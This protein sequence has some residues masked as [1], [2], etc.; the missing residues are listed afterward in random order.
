M[1]TDTAPLRRLLGNTGIN[2][3]SLGFGCY[4]VIDGN[5]AHEQALRAYLDRGGNLID[6]SANYGD[7]LAETMVEKVLQDYPDHGTILVTKGGYIQGQNMALAMKQ[8][9]PE[10]VE[11][12][13]GIW[14]CI[15]PEFLETQLR[16]SMQRLRRNYLEVYLLHNPEYYLEDQS[17]KGAVDDNHRKEFYRRVR[18]AFAFLESKVAAG[19]LGWYGISSNNFGHPESQ[20]TATSIARCWAAAESVSP[21]HHFRVVQLPLNVF[22]SGGALE[23]NNET[24]TALDYCRER[25]IGVLANRPLNA[26]QRNS[27]VRLADFMRP[28]EAAPAREQIASIVEPVSKMEKELHEQFEVPLFSGLEGGIAEYMSKMLPQIQSP[29]HWEQVYY[30]RLIQPIER[31]AMECQQLYGEHNE[32]KQWWARFVEMIPAVFEEAARYVSKSQQKISDHVRER[33]LQAGYPPSPP[34]DKSTLSQM[35]LNTLLNLDG[36]SC[37][38]VGMRRREYVDDCF[39]A[40]ALPRFDA[41][42]VLGRFALMQ[43]QTQSGTVQ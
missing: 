32:W 16:R 4:R 9:F 36:L 25:G 43:A 6:T 13:E 17:H 41:L 42:T 12:G 30:M 19:E 1:S 34:N 23:L 18:E 26:F 38:L 24:K 31:W 20:P 27:M 10:V 14:H 22:E 21:N 7:G 39:G 37:A 35:A 8:T 11:Y 5:S 33:L 3:H 40:L 15:H 2:C 29:A 28:G